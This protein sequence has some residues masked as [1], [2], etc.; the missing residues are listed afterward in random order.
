MF[1]HTYL[2][3][4]IYTYLYIY[5]RL[6]LDGNYG[7]YDQLMAMEWV[8]KNIAGFG[9]DPNRVTIDGE[10]AGAMSVYIL[11]RCK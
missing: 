8:K 7:L 5:M 10:S 9:G 4:Y 11:Y 2:T 6:G 1:I 3:I